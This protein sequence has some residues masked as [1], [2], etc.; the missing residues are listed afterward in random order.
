M[1][2]LG[3]VRSPPARHR[4][5]TA[6]AAGAQVLVGEAAGRGLGSWA[7]VCAAALDGWGK[8]GVER[9]RR[10]VAAAP[11]VKDPH[12]AG[13]ALQRDGAGALKMAGGAHAGGGRGVTRDG[14]GRKEGTGGRGRGSLLH[15]VLSVV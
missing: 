14:R 13:Y 8:G 6:G 9:V 1:P 2:S 12:V 4:A 11:A 10:L 5:A 15:L 7:A 3:R